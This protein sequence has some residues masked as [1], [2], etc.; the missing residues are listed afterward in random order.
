MDGTK[1]FYALKGEY[2]LEIL[3][4]YRTLKHTYAKYFAEPKPIVLT[5]DT[6][7]SLKLN[8]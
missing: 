1:M 8:N 4:L 7:K 2:T 6:R 3:N 5:D